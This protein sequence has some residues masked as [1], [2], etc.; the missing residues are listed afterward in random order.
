MKIQRECYHCLRRLID[1]AVNLATQDLKKKDV[2][3]RSAIAILDHE[4]SDSAIPAKIASRF[5]QTISDITGN[6]DPYHEMKR[7]AMNMAKRIFREVAPIYGNDLQSLLKLS[8]LGNAIDFFRKLEE[9]EVHIK[10]GVRFALDDI[11]KFKTLLGENV[12]TI[13]YLSD[14]AGEQYFDLP[15]VK[16]L[17]G[18]GFEV[19]YVVKEHAVQNDITMRDLESSRTL[20]QFKRVVT[21]GTATVGLD[22]NMTSKTFIKVFEE[23]G[24]IIAKGM[25]Y[26]ETLSILPDKG[27]VLHLL[28]AKCRPVAGSI[29]VPLNSYVA[30]LH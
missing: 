20:S 19:I 5:H 7:D 26:Y 1:Q 29:G 14:N 30:W 4:F 23:A 25:G 18:Q 16:W 12:K 6:K 2:A 10:G 28:M 24:V 27:N 15:L 22:L 9:I 8:V 13:L 11:K 21:T 17:E 3:R